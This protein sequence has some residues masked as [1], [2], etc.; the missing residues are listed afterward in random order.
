MNAVE[1]WEEDPA[2]ALES[3]VN[4]ISAALAKAQLEMSNPKFDTQN[5]F[6]KNRYASL[7]AVR[8]SAVPVLAKHGISLT[9]DLFTD[10]EKATVSC[11]TILRHA[12][13]QS[14]HFGPYTLPVQKADAQGFG[15]ASTYARRYHLMAVCG[16]VGD[17]DD[18]AEGSV[19]H[20]R[21]EQVLGPFQEKVKEL[22][23]S[24]RLADKVGIDGPIYDVHMKAGEDNEIY[25]A[26][27]SLLPSDMRTRL[28]KAIARVKDANGQ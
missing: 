18:D 10:L 16:V 4:E 6:F 17:A 13:G 24:F 19:E 15:S 23:E 11:T 8:D 2:P 26:A 25:R 3:K 9:Q 21:G 14:L 5:P 28:K 1:R 7:A 22:A 12:S 27:W 20:N